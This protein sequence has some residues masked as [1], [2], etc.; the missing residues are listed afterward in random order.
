MEEPRKEFSALVQIHKVIDGA[1]KAI[2]DEFKKTDNSWM[3]CFGSRVFQLEMWLS[4]ARGEIT[5]QD[6]DLYQSRL[7]ELKTDLEKL[8]QKFP[9]KNTIPDLELQEE[10]LKRLN[11]FEEY[12]RYSP[13]NNPRADNNI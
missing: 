4:M 13:Q 2:P 12:I 6:Y 1:S 5:V 8:K 9:E 7:D 11:I 10:L 3:A